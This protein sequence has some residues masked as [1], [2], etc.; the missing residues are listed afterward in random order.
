MEYTRLGT[1]G[2][3]VSRICLGMMSFGEPDRGN[4]S[5]SLGEEDSRR[6]I[7]RR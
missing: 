7:E 3:T 1:T 5:W 4:H 2:L 6:L